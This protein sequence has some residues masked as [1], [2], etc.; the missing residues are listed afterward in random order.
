MKCIGFFVGAIGCCGSRRGK[1]S[2]CLSFRAQLLFAPRLV[3][4]NFCLSGL[5]GV[6]AQWH[7][8]MHT[9]GGDGRFEPPKRFV[10]DSRSCGSKR[11]CCS[12]Q[13][14]ICSTLFPCQ[15]RRALAIGPGQCQECQPVRRARPG[16]AAGARTG[17]QLH[18]HGALVGA[19]WTDAFGARLRVVVVLHRLR[20]ELSGRH[21]LIHR[22]RGV[23]FS[24]ASSSYSDLGGKQTAC[25]TSAVSRVGKTG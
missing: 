25:T 23:L 6:D 16:S 11:G 21:R 10:V 14:S 3:A 4:S 19:G 9:E 12:T 7:N 13:K 2:A 17:A 22:V 15:E 5:E 24:I 18:L 8:L 1:A 20:E